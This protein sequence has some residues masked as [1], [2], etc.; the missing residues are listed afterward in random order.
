[1]LGCTLPDGVHWQGVPGRWGGS[2]T[3]RPGLVRR[4]TMPVK[5]A[6]ASTGAD[7][8]IFPDDLEGTRF[9]LVEDALYDASE[10]RESLYD[11]RAI[12]ADEE[13]HEQ[14]QV[15]AFGRWYPVDVPGHEDDQW[16]IAPGELV[17]E[18]KT[19]DD[20]AGARLKVT[21]CRKS[22]SRESDPYEVNVAPAPES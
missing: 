18:L 17:D 11:N 10:V 9:H 4:R 5:T 15:P 2:E 22:G 21:R 6:D 1:M 7:G 13:A 12:E 3:A 16:M 19:W 8:F 14:G 20:P